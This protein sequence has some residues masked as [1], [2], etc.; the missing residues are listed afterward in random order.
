LH[1]APLLA[2]DEQ[3][4]SVP[5]TMPVGLW[6][7]LERCRS[8]SRAD[9][10]AVQFEEL[11]RILE[12]WPEVQ[13]GESAAGAFASERIGALLRSGRRSGYAA[14][15]ERAAAAYATA[16]AARDR[17]ALARIPRLYPGSD[18][19]RAA[20]DALLDWASEALDAADVAA[21]VQSELPATWTLAGADEREVRLC[22]RQAAVHAE[23]GNRELADEFVRTL[24]E[25]RPEVV[26]EAPDG[27]G[28]P[29]GE[30][31]AGL[32]R[33][34]P[35]DHTPHPGRFSANCKQI[36][37]WVGEHELLGFALPDAAADA[38]PSE[39]QLVV[40]HLQ[41]ERRN[42]RLFA[43]DARDP[44]TPAWISEFT[45]DNL[46][47]QSPTNYW[48]RHV[49][50]AA[51][52]IVVAGDREVF[53]LNAADGT[54]AWEWRPDAGPMLTITLA[55]SAGV[56]VA[57]VHQPGDRYF[58]Q[59]LDARNGTELWREGMQDA[60]VQR[61]PLL[62]S[63]RVVFLPRVGLKQ[64]IVRDLFTGR[65]ERAIDLGVPVSST[66]EQDA[67]IEGDHLIIPWFAPVLAKAERNQISAY[68]LGAGTLA[69]RV[70]F[71][72]QGT[73]RRGLSGIV[74]H[75]E[76]TYLIVSAWPSAERPA[77]A[78][79]LFE[80][81]TGIGALTPLSNIRLGSEDRLFGLP[82]RGGRLRVGSPYV[83]LRSSRSGV[84]EARL[85][86]I[87]LT[88]GE[89]WVQSL[90]V[91]VEDIYSLPTPAPALSES[92]VAIAYTL[93]PMRT[94]QQKP[95]T[96]A[97]FDRTTG[98]RRGERLLASAHG[99][100]D[101]LQLVPLGDALIVKGKDQLEILE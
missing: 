40:V 47:P 20:N 34:V 52:R 31:A 74:Q 23:L 37:R 99:A 95:T 3:S 101:R 1:Y 53:G 7:A 30:L 12:R 11:H 56:V 4:D 43:L 88:S 84:G 28:R 22:L 87:D 59:A 8:A 33:W 27:T 24:A 15:E 94:Q 100:S 14:F 63:N 77:A 6:V 58:V 72:D 46:P 73:E 21:I 69:W 13:L 85:R 51:G 90:P 5:C 65:R 80:L 49:A 19:A 96:L 41:R 83:Y 78:N 44:G 70:G 45:L 35:G 2:V 50:F 48:S 82:T 57:V 10:A 67:W 54:R 60:F 75:A 64:T 26:S 89:L 29:L 66:V 55:C 9:D 79:M 98:L 61:T 68:D 92:S 81:H 39:R 36:A 91:P 32:P 76:Q 25:V 17:A 97:F 18:A 42:A 62:A 16:V 93:S 71:D 86:A 38:A